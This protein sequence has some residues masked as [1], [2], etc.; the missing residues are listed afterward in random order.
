MEPQDTA[1]DAVDEEILSELF[2]MLDDGTS[3]G[4]VRAC[5][6][7]L[8]GVPS[9]LTEIEAALA[10]QRFDHAGRVAHTLRGTAGAFGA[11]RLGR[12][13]GRLEDRCRQA[14]GESPEAIAAAMQAEF[15]V[16][17]DIL[18]SRLAASSVVTAS[19]APAAD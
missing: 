5:D 13:A 11:V 6:M 12:L 9:S 15:L 16:F 4:L 7:F 8:V 10:E 17:R 3:D 14:D 1:A 19:P 18:A 2:D